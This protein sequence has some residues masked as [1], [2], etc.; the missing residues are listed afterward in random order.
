M[1]LSWRRSSDAEDR[2][3]QWIAGQHQRRVLA[4]ETTPSGPCPDEKF[5]RDLA[6]RSSD[7]SLSDPRVDHAATCPTCM[8]RLLALRQEHRLR[9][10]KVMIAAVAASCAILVAAVFVGIY[11]TRHT[12]P[13]EN[14]IAVSQTVDLWDAGTVRGEQPGQLQAVSLPAAHI[15]L[16]IVLPRHSTPGQYLVAITRD[17]SGNGLIA[18]GLAPTSRTGDKEE[19][20]TSIDLSKAQAGRYFLSTTHEK[21]Q[22]AYYYPLQV[23]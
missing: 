8:T 5:L 20:T 12:P 9:R 16:T 13:T 19:I 4:G 6:R 18:E 10:R 1:R 14:A 17:Q 2:F 22:A 23:K 11:T 3:E 15:N 7:I 21:D